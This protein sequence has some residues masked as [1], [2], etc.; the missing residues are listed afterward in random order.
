MEPM[1][2]DRKSIKTKRLTVR[3]PEPVEKMIRNEAERRGTNMNQTML[4]IITEYLK[5]QTEE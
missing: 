4:Y 2:K 5:N 3:V 1:E